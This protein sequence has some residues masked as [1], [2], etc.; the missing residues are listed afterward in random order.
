MRNIT[1]RRAIARFDSLDSYGTPHYSISILGALPT[2]LSLK[3][4]ELKSYFTG[5]NFQMGNSP[6]IISL[7]IEKISAMNIF[8]STPQANPIT[9]R[10]LL[11]SGSLTDKRSFFTMTQMFIA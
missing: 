6:T 8:D 7:L 1:L 4:F 5:H 3:F 9:Q 10:P 11:I 2:L